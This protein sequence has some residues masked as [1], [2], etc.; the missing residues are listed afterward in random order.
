MYQYGLVVQILLVAAG[1]IIL[2]I[3]VALL[4]KRKLSEP[5]SVTWGFAAIIFI[6]AG[7]FLR[8]NGWINYISPAGLIMLSI[9]GVLALVGLFMASSRMS[10]LIRKNTEMAMNISLLNQ[11]IVELKKD[12]A[13]NHRRIEEKLK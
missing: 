3:D 8:P 1:V 2:V 6:L 11:E 5:I 4:A 12:I 10:E 9:L 7:I 13:E